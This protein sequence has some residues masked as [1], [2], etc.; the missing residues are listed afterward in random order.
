M[1]NEK[2]IEQNTF[3]TDF[4]EHITFL[5]PVVF[6]VIC[7]LLVSVR[8]SFVVHRSSIA[9]IFDSA[10]SN[11]NRISLIVFHRLSLVLSPVSS[12]LDPTSRARSE[13]WGCFPNRSVRELGTAE[14]KTCLVYLLVVV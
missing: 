7:S 8:C 14:K 9:I 3:K 5:I 4:K 6:S 13:T 2:T 10:F 12:V 11:R 1:Y